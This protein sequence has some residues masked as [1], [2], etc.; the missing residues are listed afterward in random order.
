MK[1]FLYVLVLSLECEIVR[2][3]VT[4]KGQIN[5]DWIVHN[6]EWNA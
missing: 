3:S 6:I 4:V 2:V 5:V 1:F